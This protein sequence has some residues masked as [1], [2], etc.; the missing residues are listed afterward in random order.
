MIK[1]WGD[2]LAEFEDGAIITSHH[3]T[4]AMQDEIDELRAENAALLA[5]NRDSM[6]HYNELRA[7]L[8]ALKSQPHLAVFNIAIN[9]S[10][11]AICYDFAKH[12]LPAGTKFYLAPGAQPVPDGMVLVPI[13][14]TDAML[15]KL[16]YMGRSRVVSGPN[17]SDWQPAAIRHWK[18]ML[19]AVK[20]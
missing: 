14:L 6:D 8:D 4:G 20:Q 7:E 19:E 13:D 9:E 12:K 5:A 10:V 15:E 16:A 17:K 18:A 3:V 1:T 2:R 11:G